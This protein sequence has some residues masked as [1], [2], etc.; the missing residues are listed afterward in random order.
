MAL[1]NF[2]TP[3][4]IRNIIDPTQDQEV[5][6]KHYVD[7]LIGGSNTGTFANL[8]VTGN[9]TVGGNLT[10]SGNL[11]VANVTYTNQEIVT[12]TET[13]TG[14]IT[15]T[16][17]VTANAVYT[18]N[19]YYANGAPVVT[20]ITVG[21]INDS[22]TRSNTVVGVSALRFDANAG[23]SVHDLGSGE[24]KVSLGSTFKTWVVAGQT[25][26]VAS[27]EDTV[28]FIAGNGIAISTHA[29]APKTITFDATYGNLNVADY[30]TTYSGNIAAGNI[31]ATNVYTDHLFYANGQPYVTG[32]S[33]YSN[34]YNNAIVIANTLTELDRI[35]TSGNTNV[36]W[37]ITAK[38]NVGGYIK[39]TTVDTINDGSTVYYDEYSVLLSNDLHE[40]VTITSTISNGNVILYGTGT[41]ANVS[42]QFQRLALGSGTA[43]GYINTE[44][45][46]SGGGFGNAVVS[47]PNLQNMIYVAKN[48]NDAYDGT[49]ANPF[50][51][52]KAALAVATSGT[53]VFVAPGT[54]TENNP[55]TIPAGVSLI[56]DNLRSVTVIPQNP[57]S[58]IFYM[59]N[60]NYVWGL[61]VKDY[62]ANAFAYDPLTSNQNVYVS[63]YIQ[64][65]T[66]TTTTGTAVKIDGSLTS[67]ASTKAMIVGFFTIINKGGKGV[68]IT[69]SGYSQLVNIYTIACDQGIVCESG[70]FCTLNGSDT[71]IGNY[72]L[73]ADGKGPELANGKSYG[74][75]VNGTFQIR[76]LA[77]PPRVN[78]VMM[79][80]GD[81]SYYSIDN[82]TQVDNQTWQVDIQE[83][84]TGPL[85][86]NTTIRFYQRSAIVASAH[87]FEYVG[88][89]TDPATAL[90][91]YG[92]IPVAA[93]EVVQTNGGKVTFTA[94]DHK[95]NFKIGANLTINQTTGAITGDAF[96]KSMFALMTPYI[97]ALQ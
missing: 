49:M 30:L 20:T 82:I 43:A 38:D 91:Q 41:S 76:E 59:R 27:G 96:S 21:E 73:V 34:I 3:T 37:F 42:V 46:G 65:I 39:S 86:A 51:T 80:D 14:D 89:G 23:F 74:T 88:A 44:L 60:K 12:T 79:I 71:S 24:V 84:Y 33:A 36:R 2:P 1:L 18:D 48:G 35:P 4:T 32:S 78:Q 16:G 31:S 68:H 7:G 50:L 29:T 94:T 53:T 61:T 47:N 69:N 54:Y 77:T 81:S 92:G 55:I 11:I 22:N 66:S 70:A 10:V 5:A 19:Y 56:G 28:E 9:A 95:G 90:P 97:L 45:I 8:S 13:V 87:T 58:D 72:G 64:N 63:P 62:L 17:N 85:A 67:A 52:I 57:S 75:S 83:F 26:L 25:S 93:N 6:T 15:A 40:V